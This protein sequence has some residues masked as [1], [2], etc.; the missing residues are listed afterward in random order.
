MQAVAARF[1]GENGVF[2]QFGDSLTVAAPNQRWAT[3]GMG[4]TGEERAFLAWAHAGTRD[5][6]DGWHLASTPTG[7][8]DEAPRAH[9]AGVGC[10]SRVLLAGGRGLPP[11]SLMIARF[12]PQMAVYAVGMSDIIRKVGVGDYLP[13]VEAAIDLLEANG[14]VPVLSTITPAKAHVAE[15]DAANA[16]LRAFARDRRLPLLDIHAEMSRRTRDVTEYLQEDGIHLTWD[17]PVG[18]ATQENLRRSGYLLRCWLTV[19][20]GM[21]VRKRVLAPV[22]GRRRGE[23][24]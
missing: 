17:P 18:P 8:E 7:P 21:E 1:R 10:S 16:A 6:R 19:R 3:A 2:L 12:N 22:A 4:H 24:Q 23:G 14:T 15:V 20:K 11:L 5:L 13:A 9:T